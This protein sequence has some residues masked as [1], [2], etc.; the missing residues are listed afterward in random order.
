M[1]LSLPSGISGRQNAPLRPHRQGR[2]GH[3]VRQQDT[4][5]TATAA[6]RLHT[7]TVYRLLADQERQ[8]RFR[9]AKRK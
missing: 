8:S 7:Q 2:S 4:P 3:A 6:F 9:A 5:A 1:I